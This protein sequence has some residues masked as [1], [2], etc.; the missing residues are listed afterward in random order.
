MANTMAHGHLPKVVKCPCV[1][2]CLHTSNTP[3]FITSEQGRTGIQLKTTPG[4]EFNI[5]VVHFEIPPAVL[6]TH[7]H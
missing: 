1:S 2:L 3:V 7:D 4:S 6:S 5:L